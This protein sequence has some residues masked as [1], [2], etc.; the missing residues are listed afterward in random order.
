ME[1]AKEKLAE[2]AAQK[3]FEQRK[4]EVQDTG[5]MMAKLFHQQ[6]VLTELLM[7][8]K[9][10]TKKGLQEKDKEIRK[11]FKKF[12]ENPIKYIKKEILDGKLSSQGRQNRPQSEED[13]GGSRLPS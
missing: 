3:E 9:V 13:S 12:C 2:L 1:K 10:I 11:R 7:D 5:K 4:V 6:T 8:K